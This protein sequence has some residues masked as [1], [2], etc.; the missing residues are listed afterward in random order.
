M[1]K[2]ARLS[3]GPVMQ[4]T[5]VTTPREECRGREKDMLTIRSLMKKATEKGFCADFEKCWTNSI[6][7]S[8]N[9]KETTTNIAGE[10]IEISG[11]IV[12]V[13]RISDHHPGR[14]RGTVTHYLTYNK[15]IE[16]KQRVYSDAE[17]IIDSLK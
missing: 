2:S 1:I 17:K 16:N 15:R 6:Y 7:L 3:P 14:Y 9:R 13:I 10:P 11:K 12:A 4:A 8:I 5:A